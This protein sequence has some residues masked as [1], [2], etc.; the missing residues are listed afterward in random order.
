MMEVS[1][2]NKIKM[3]DMHNQNIKD[4]KAVINL[5][6]IINKIQII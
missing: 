1:F 4:L 6:E 3:I 2:I 5:K